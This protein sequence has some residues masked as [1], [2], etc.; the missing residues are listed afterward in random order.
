M[1]KEI[2]IQKTIGFV[3]ML[4]IGGN[5]FGEIRPPFELACPPS[6]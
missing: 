2:E 6:H 5:S 4:I 3:M 1:L